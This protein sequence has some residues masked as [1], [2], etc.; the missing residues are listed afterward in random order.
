MAFHDLTSKPSMVPAGIRSLLGLGLNFC[1]TPTT[2]PKNTNDSLTRFSRDA[3]TKFFWAG[4]PPLLATD[5]F[6]RSD[7]EPNPDEIPAEFRARLSA[8][9]R[10][11]KL[12]FRRRRSR[13][14]L[15]PS[16]LTAMASL[17]RDDNLIVFKTDKNLGPAIL[18]RPNYIKVALQEHLQ[19]TYTYRQLS[20]QQATGRLRAVNNLIK[21]FIQVH[22][23]KGSSD[24][25]FLSRSLNVS[26]PFA[27]FYLLA[28]VHKKPWVT[29]PIVSVSGSISHGLGRW[30]DNQL[31]R[32]VKH[33]PYYLKSSTEL[34]A[35]LGTTSNFSPRARFF[36]MDATSMYTN[37]DTKHALD[38]IKTFLLHTHP[39]ICETE[40]IS[41][42]A[43]MAAMKI[44]MYHNV[45]KFGDTC[46]VQLTGT[47]MGTPPAPM[48][49][50]LYFAI[51]EYNVIPKTICLPF[52]RRYI[53][54][55]FGIW[56]PPI[57]FD[58]ST[59][60]SHWNKFINDINNFGKLK[61]SFSSLTTVT[62]FLDI[63]VTLRHD[64]PIRTRLYEKA[65][66]LY[67]YLPPHTCHP[68]GILS[69]TIAGMI[70]RIYRLTSDCKDRN[71]SIINFFR[72]LRLRGYSTQTLRPIFNQ[73]IARASQSF[74]NA[75]HSTDPR[76]FFHLPFHPLNPSSFRIQCAFKEHMYKPVGEPE[77]PSIKNSMG[78]PFGVSRMIIANHRPRNIGNYVAPRRLKEYAAPVSTFLRD[79]T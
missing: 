49:A 28:K 24:A 58:E 4:S 38:E 35:L 41:V 5:L 70:L 68:P 65:L 20:F 62:D 45:F 67:L 25:K 3:S 59:T 22:C 1:P 32:I 34:V 19:D 46:W 21:N 48:Y 8:F 54:D 40:S 60:T 50:T 75:D 61:W 17:R 15:L 14:N 36:T 33:L 52:Y 72:R 76:L 16:Q 57:A 7:W 37:I 31:Q 26:D 44:I 13:R 2:T 69:G 71:A 64:M 42:P 9:T 74:T 51:H 63:T 39:S 11:M 18:E 23:A 79:D 78:Q 30:L 27:Y 66:N 56:D 29:R 6:I 12:M 55:G 77:L 53:D 47:A 73:H 43:I 10:A